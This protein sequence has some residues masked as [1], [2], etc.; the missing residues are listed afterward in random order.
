MIK[1]LILSLTFVL[2]V[3]SMAFAEGFECLCDCK[4]KA[5]GGVSKIT[6]DHPDGDHMTCSDAYLHTQCGDGAGEITGCVI[7]PKNKSIRHEGNEPVNDF[8]EL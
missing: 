7:R 3:S 6:R 5:E 4:W 8:F 2:S 1:N